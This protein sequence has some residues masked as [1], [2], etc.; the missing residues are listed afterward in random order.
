V[1]WA[2]ALA[3]LLLLGSVAAAIQAVRGRR[4]D[5]SRVTGLR[6]ELAGLRARV[7]ALETRQRGG[8]GDTLTSQLVLTA[9]APPAR[10][11]AELTELLPPDVRFDSV[12]FG[13]GDSLEIEANVV[14]RRPDAYD[15]FMERLAGSPSFMD[16]VPGPEVRESEMRSS[17]RMSYGRA[18]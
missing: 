10:V 7:Q 14:A 12:S 1:T 5:E 18:P 17:V 16:V 3:A 4:A 13:Y 15:V 8:G 2:L 11:L 6:R 9:E